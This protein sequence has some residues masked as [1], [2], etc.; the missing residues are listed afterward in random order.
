M[1]KAPGALTLY[2]CLIDNAV[3]SFLVRN[4]TRQEAPNLEGKVRSQSSGS[5]K[6][7]IRKIFLELIFRRYHQG[8]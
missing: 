2:I 6:G 8:N 3:L 1:L 5:D 4:S 7:N